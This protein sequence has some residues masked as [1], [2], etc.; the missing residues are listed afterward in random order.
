MEI[1][2]AIRGYAQ[3]KASKL[4]RYFSRIIAAEVI[5]GMDGGSPTVEVVVNAP[6]NSTFIGT[7]R[8]DDM[9]GCIDNAIH[10]VEEQ[11]RRHK[12][13]VRDHKGP[14]HEIKVDLAEAP[15]REPENP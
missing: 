6:H 13:K 15:Y 1:T 7:H 3:E 5:I 8:G 9:Y 4:Q 11:I 12:D 10:K 2:D 14:G